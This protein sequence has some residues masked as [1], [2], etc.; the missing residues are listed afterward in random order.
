MIIVDT[1]TMVASM[2]PDQGLPARA[3][4]ALMRDPHWAAPIHQPLEFLNSI[5][6]LALGK[7][8]TNAVAASALER[9]R[10]SRIEYFAVTGEME[11]MERIWEL[12]HN[13]TPYDAAYVALGES[14]DV[15]V[16][17]CDVK[18]ATASGPRCQF[19]LIR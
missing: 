3:R 19:Q 1:T 9:F 2:L 4:A 17:T 5:R 12:R 16:L 18:L 15:T 10:D 7:K 13:V 11:L 8:I 6:G 14:L